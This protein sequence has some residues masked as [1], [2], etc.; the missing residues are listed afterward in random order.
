MKYNT[1]R[2]DGVKNRVGRVRR[3]C[4]LTIFVLLPLQGW[5][6][7]DQGG[8]VLHEYVRQSTDVSLRLLAGMPSQA[9][10]VVS[11]VGIGNAM[12]VLH[13]GAG[14]ETANE[15]KRFLA[16]GSNKESSR[17]GDPL[18]QLAR[19]FQTPDEGVEI[20]SFNRIY[21]EKR[22]A[23]SIGK[24]F[25][26][27]AKAHYQ[28]KVNYVDM[29]TANPERQVN[30]WV[31][32]K[33]QGKISSLLPP[34]ALNRN[35]IAVLGNVMTFKGKWATP[36]DPARTELRSFYDGSGVVLGLVPMMMGE[37]TLGAAQIGQQLAYELPFQGNRYALR[38][39]PIPQGV[40]LRTWQESLTSQTLHEL[41]KAM[42]KSRCEMVLPR[43]HI[44][45][46]SQAIKPALAQFGLT[47]LFNGSADFTPMLGKYG[48]GANVDNIYHAAGI[49]IDEAGAVATS[50]T[51]VSLKPKSLKPVCQLD[52]PFLFEVVQRNTGI[53]LFMGYLDAPVQAS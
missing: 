33:T 29:S 52:R 7:P 26:R 5:A 14:G 1:P 28:T 43:F 41:G 27:G 17:M 13:L 44:A 48:M 22:K 24:Q 45:P 6:G 23:G 46:T 18:V 11:P 12:A 21:V 34:G 40:N 47:S 19:D 31:A 16:V 10:R 3:H 51:A 53:P 15:L 35:T 8:P 49:S 25:L 20:S 32:V 2:H 4:V 9:G 39:F 50:S 36:F 30:Q 37:V 42:Q 38:L